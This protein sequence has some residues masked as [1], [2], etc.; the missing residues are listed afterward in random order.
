[1]TVVDET[2]A[3]GSKTHPAGTTSVTVKVNEST[4]VPTLSV[5]TLQEGWLR[6]R[7]CRRLDGDHDRVG[8][9]GHLV[10]GDNEGD[11]VAADGQGDRRVAP[12]A[13]WVPS[14]VQS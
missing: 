1:M 2:D 6:W 8:V 7:W 9:G 3:S 13:I 5:E 11:R 12:V 10:V 14:S 4:A